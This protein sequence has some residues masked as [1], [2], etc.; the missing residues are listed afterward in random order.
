MRAL[1]LPLALAL[2][3]G[4]LAASPQP[5]PPRPPDGTYTY[6]ISAPN[7]AGIKTTIVIQS[8][9]AVLNVGEQASLPGST[10]VL[11]RESYDTTTLL[12]THYEV[13]Q[14]SASRNADLMGTITPS[15]ITFSGTPLSYKALDGT[16]F[17]LVG[18]GLGAY[19]LMMPFTLRA[20]DAPFTFAA[21]N[22]NQTLQGHS[23][24]VTE[25]RPQGARSND[26]SFAVQIGTDT[27]TYWYDPHTLIPDVIDS[28]Q[29]AAMHLD[30]YNASITKLVEPPAVSHAPLAFAHYTDS[31][32]SVPSTDGAVLSGTLSVPDGGSQRRPAI[33]FVHGSGPGTRD[34]GTAA[35]PTFLFLANSLANAGVVVLRYDKRGIGKS[36]GT[37]TEDWR[38]L[39]DDLRAMVS[40]LKKSPD[41]DPN[42]I[43]LLGHSEGGLVVPLAANSI[44]PR[45]IVL[46]AGPAISL[47]DILIKQGFNQMAAGEQKALSDAFA[48]YAGID[49]AK[50]IAGVRAPMLL[51]QGGKDDQVLASDFPLL[52]RAAK[53]AH[54]D[55]TA[56]VFPEDD[57]L[58]IKLPP[59]QAMQGDELLKP[60]P[61]DPRVAA[62]ILTFIHSY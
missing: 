45:G 13:H 2:A 54:R 14:R 62:R 9:G 22:G 52:V 28:A 12:P 39:G 31:D 5:A 21:L 17:V 32:V 7:G 37:A 61:L 30:A 47:H 49:P 48:G 44:D 15:S 25:A 55:V 41:V 24:K 51:L 1:T 29:G 43:F 10:S 56:V 16:K 40:Y 50:V 53:A 36:T 38:P 8:A 27:L 3:A 11:V 46:M 23:V 59:S 42:R 33:V 18:E 20:N 4:T 6:S 35:N 60:F 57:H 26:E 34:G 19:R 58:F